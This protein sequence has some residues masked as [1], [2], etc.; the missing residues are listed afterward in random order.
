MLTLVAAALIAGAPAPVYKEIKPT[1]GPGV[2]GVYWCGVSPNWVTLNK[3]GTYDWPY[4]GTV[5][6]GTWGYEEKTKTLYMT[7]TG[8]G[9]Q[10][11]TNYAFKMCDTCK[12]G[13]HVE[14]RVNDDGTVTETGYNVQIFHRAK[15]GAVLPPLPTSPYTP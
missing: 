2:Y 9:G 11:W 3:D 8:D 10:T 13:K 1:V 12:V 7:N 4:C 6:K 5:H 15:P 14:R